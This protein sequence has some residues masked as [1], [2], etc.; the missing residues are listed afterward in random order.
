MDRY[1]IIFLIT[2][3][4]ILNVSSVLACL[5]DKRPTFSGSF[6]QSA[7]VFSGKVIKAEYKKHISPELT[8]SKAEP[9][10]N[11]AEYEVLV[12]TFEVERWWKGG[13]TAE[14]LL[15]TGQAKL[16]NGKI[17]VTTCEYEYTLGEKYLVFAQGDKDR[18]VS[19]ICTLT[20]KLNE[21]KKE[22][23]LLGEGTEPEKQTKPDEN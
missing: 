20:N 3:I 23:E 15:V 17:W 21:A 9:T 16:S 2:A 18:L 11:K 19:G 8:E 7:A 10:D 1:K 12:I 22:L 14:V 4:L 13:T 6:E 5:C